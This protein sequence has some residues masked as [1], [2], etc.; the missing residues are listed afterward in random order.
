MADDM[1]LDALGDRCA[2]RRTTTSASGR[3][4]TRR[5]IC[6]STPVFSA[7]SAGPGAAPPRRPSLRAPSRPRRS[8]ASIRP[9]GAAVL[10]G[11]RSAVLRDCAG[12]RR[13]RLV[14]SLARRAGCIGPRPGGARR[15]ERPG[16][17]VGPGRPTPTARPAERGR[18][19]AAAPP[20]PTRTRSD[21][22]HTGRCADRGRLAAATPASAADLTPGVGRARLRLSFSA[23]SW[24]DVHDCDG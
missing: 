7:C 4:S 9:V 16:A 10:S 19:R 17:A 14:A 22:P 24:V 23:D 6:E 20:K 15:G 2:R 13:H 1:H 12:G 11:R 18:R 21:G 5:G 8:F 3:R